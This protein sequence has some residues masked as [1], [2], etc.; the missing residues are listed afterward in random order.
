MRVSLVT[1]V[2]G[3]LIAGLTPLY[4]QDWDRAH[5]IMGKTQEDLHR[6]ERHDRWA[7]ADRGH[8]DAA[9]RNLAD[10]Q[11]DLDHNRLDRRRLEDTIREIEFI[12]HVDALD[13]RA[14][15]ALNSDARELHRLRDEWHWR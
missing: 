4:A 12:T 3:L 15:E 11:R 10:V 8:Y 14:R 13:A 2:A 5:R 7:Q 6:I 9:E 1:A